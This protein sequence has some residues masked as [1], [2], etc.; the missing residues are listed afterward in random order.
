MMPAVSYIDSSYALSAHL[1]ASGSYSW[2]TAPGYT[3][4]A[5]FSTL[6][7]FGPEMRIMAYNTLVTSSALGTLCD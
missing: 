1:S 3:L 7:S 4:A 5:T 2:P 6:Y